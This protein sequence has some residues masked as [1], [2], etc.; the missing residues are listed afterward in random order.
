M[1]KKSN[2]NP[3]QSITLISCF[4]CWISG[5]FGEERNSPQNGHNIL[6]RPLHC[7]SDSIS[8][9]HRWQCDIMDGMIAE[10]V[11]RKEFAIMKFMTSNFLFLLLISHLLCH[12][13]KPI[14]NSKIT[15]L[16]RWLFFLFVYSNI[17]F[18]VL[19]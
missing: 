1:K 14:T 18:Y 16:T 19:I 6:I 3:I 10:E 15:W 8:S 2:C 7:G 17:L 5:R 11:R 9:W 12:W 13:F 4:N